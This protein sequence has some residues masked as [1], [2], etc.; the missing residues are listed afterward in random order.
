M[1]RA[2]KTSGFLGLSIQMLWG[3]YNVF[4]VSPMGPGITETFQVLVGGHAHLGVLSI[5]AVALG[6]AVDYY[7]LTGARRTVVTW[8]FIAGQWL[9][10]ATIIAIAMGYGMVAISAYLWGLLLFVSMAV[11][12]WT[13]ATDS[14]V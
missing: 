13:A 5:L 9:L 6:L 3:M 12:T 8:F 2:L 14:G 4:V 1:S 11:M 7:R 10:P